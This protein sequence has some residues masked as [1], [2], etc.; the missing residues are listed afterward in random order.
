M[1][2]RKVAVCLLLGCALAPSAVAQ[3]LEPRSYSVSPQGT[4]FLV[5]SYGRSTGDVAFDPTLPF[6]DVTATIN[7]L[8]IGY[9]RSVNVFGRS[10]N[11][12]ASVPLLSGSIQGLV[13]GSFQQVKR[14]GLGDPRLR[15]AV[16][17]VGAPA[18]DLSE[19]VNYQQDT[20]VGLSLVAVPPLGEYDSSKLINIGSNRWSFKPELGL[21]KAFGRWMLDF[22]TGVWIFTDN[23]DFIGLVRAQDPLGVSQLHLSYTVRPRL[24]AAFDATFYTG[25]RTEI[26]GVKGFDF[27]RNSRLG[28]T[29][30]IPLD[31]HRSLKVAVSTG[32]LTTVGADFDA[33]T[34]AYQFLWGVGG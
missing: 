19:F 5:V 4:N 27:Q 11:V 7:T 9:F 31:R 2:R 20:I 8:A 6:E 24:W 22:Y 13:S 33:L 1:A 23:E 28:G 14:A 30:A 17:L 3:E 34:I 32:A 12:T 26:N 21:S 29:L 16:N 15:F 25:G 10:A 18:M